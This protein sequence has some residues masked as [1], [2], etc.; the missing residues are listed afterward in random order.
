MQN[1]GFVLP[2]F[3]A[4]GAWLSYGLGSMSADLPTFVVL[5]DSRGFAPNGPGNWTA[6]FLPAAHQGTMIRPAAANPIADLFPA[7][8]GRGSF[9][10]RAKQPDFDGV[11]P[12]QSRF[13]RRQPAGRHAARA[14]R[15]RS[16][17]LAGAA[18]NAE[19]RSEKRARTWQTK[20]RELSN[21]TD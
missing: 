3:P 14:R 16:Y 1:S 18:A 12:T 4:M 2:G 5:P 19:L 8:H 13:T 10:P 17:E 9:A 7:R 11:G 15:I 21:C 20:R 6:G